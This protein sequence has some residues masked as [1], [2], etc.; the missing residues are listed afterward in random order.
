MLEVLWAAEKSTKLGNGGGGHAKEKIRKNP[1]STEKDVLP[2]PRCVQ[3]QQ[4]G[5]FGTR[6]IMRTS[7]EPLCPPTSADPH[8]KK[9]KKAKN[10]EDG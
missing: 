2:V 10:W 1:Y 3:R 6:S 9:K 5:V 7:V 8:K 4:G